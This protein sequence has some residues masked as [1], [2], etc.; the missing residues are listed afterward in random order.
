VEEE[1][2]EEGRDRRQ[3]MRHA[4]NTDPT[5]ESLMQETITGG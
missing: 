1:E 4:T 3:T 2:E 5:V